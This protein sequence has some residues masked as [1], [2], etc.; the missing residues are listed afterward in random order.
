MGT[1]E[2]PRD[3]YLR[4]ILYVVFKWK[5]LIFS[6]FLAIFL[7]VFV[8]VVTAPRSYE[9][10]ATLMLKRERGELVLSPN[11]VAGG[12]VNLRVN[13]DQDLR[14]ETELLRRRSLLAQVVQTVGPQVVLRGSLQS[15]EIANGNGGM[16]TVK[17]LSLSSLQGA[18]GAMRP[19]LAMPVRT[20]GWLNPKE[21]TTDTDQ[22]ILRLGGRLKVIPIENSNLIKVT[23][24]AQDPR[25]AAT[26]LDL[27]VKNYLEQY[28][29]IRTTPGAADFFKQQMDGLSGELRQAENAMQRFE[30]EQG[31]TS[32]GRQREIY[33]TKAVDREST[34]QLTRSEVKEL[35]EKSRVL[36]EQLQN[37]PDK[38]QTTEEIRTNPVW[39]T[40]RS[41]LLDL[42]VERN[43]LLQKYMEQDRRVTDIEREIDLL[44][45]RLLSEPPR[46]S[47]KESYGANPVRNPL[48]Q[49]L[50]NTEVQMIRAQVKT[51]NLER[52]MK[53]FYSR[54]SHVDQM[55]YERARHE[56][57][58]KI[59]EDAYL[60]YTKKYEET[61]AA[62]AM[63][64][65]RIV[66]V[67]LAEPVQISPMPGAGG[68]SGVQ[69]LFL[70]AIVGLV[71]G[72]GGAFFRESFG[73]SVTTG[74]SVRRHLGLPVLSSISEEKE[75]K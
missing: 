57:K 20:L 64:R 22:A 2:K 30:A 37:L 73:R 19:V 49:E 38:I 69:L 3:A 71:S 17:L 32:L 5:R 35:Q 21:P 12:N 58:V 13:P 47:G 62:S 67:A 31:I 46:E 53:D 26:V 4:E 11:Q 51:V 50:I 60:L 66:N 55:A 7:G 16:N 42:E 9:A 70:G 39:D 23:F 6:V 33:L 65:N 52:D 44:R 29:Q 68:R 72:V 15:E 34:L 43:K 54:L 61:R 24:V 63:D 45:E 40:V 59:L 41:K 27:L 56:R 36:R 28:A 1:Q 8:A 75:K 10:S 14:S 74:E 18:I 25:F 48:L